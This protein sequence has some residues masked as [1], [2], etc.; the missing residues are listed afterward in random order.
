MNETTCF[1]YLN[2]KNGMLDLIRILG[3][4][5]INIKDLLVQDLIDQRENVVEIF[6]F[7]AEFD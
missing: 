5:L 6:W 1:L 3:I 4:N 7:V 2:I